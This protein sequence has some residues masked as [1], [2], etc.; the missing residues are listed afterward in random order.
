MN[1]MLIS[2]RRISILFAFV[3]S[4]CLFSACNLVNPPEDFPAYIK[5]EDPRVLVDSVAGFEANYDLQDLWVYQNGQLIGV[6]PVPKTVIPYTQIDRTEFRFEAGVYESGLSNFRLPYP[7]WELIQ[8][9]IDQATLDTFTLSPVFR[10]KDDDKIDFRFEEDFESGFQL[11]PY[12]PVVDTA[13]MHRSTSDA[14]QGAASG[15]VEFSAAKN[16]WEA[17]S[18]AQFIN[19]SPTQDPWLEITY[20]SDVLLDVGMR[21][22]PDGS[23]LE[24]EVRAA[25]TL[26]PKSMDEWTTVYVHLV[27]LVRAAPSN[28]RFAIWLRGRS[29]GQEGEL[30]LDNLRL[31]HLD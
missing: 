29:F 7:F 18:T 11:A 21:Y 13:K 22:W 12:G 25:V 9:R 23:P 19:I 31:V 20:K 2:A 17:T 16:T 30:F 26:L 8:L 1:Q 3:L 4:I 10:Y 15:R 5:V 28:A 6:H 14:F 24:E 27:D